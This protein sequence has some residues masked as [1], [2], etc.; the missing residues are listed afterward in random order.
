LPVLDASHFNCSSLAAMGSAAIESAASRGPG[1]REPSAAQNETVIQTCMQCGAIVGIETGAE[2][3]IETGVET[4]VCCVCGARLS[5]KNPEDILVR[6]ST[7]GAD[8][9]AEESPAE[10][11]DNG[12]EA[13]VWRNEVAY[14]VAAY[15][16]RGRR[17]RSRS[18]QPE[19]RFEGSG[20]AGAVARKEAGVRDSSATARATAAP[21]IP[22]GHFNRSPVNRSTVD[23]NTVDSSA[24]SVS[25]S[26]R[27]V[28]RSSHTGNRS[29]H[30][31]RRQRTWEDHLVIDVSQP[32]LN[33]TSVDY[34]PQESAQPLSESDRPCSA[35]AAL[36]E[37][38]R[39]GAIDAGL[40]LFAYGGFLAL[41]WVLGGRFALSALDA[42]ITAA[43]LGLLYAQYCFLFAVF[44]GA[45]PGMMA[46]GLNVVSF[47]GTEPNTR[48]LL[49]RS[50]GYLASAGV[51]FAGFL[52]ALWDRD[53][54]TWHDR[55]SHTYIT[56]R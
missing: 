41:F 51:G 39:A 38:A 13:P 46:R 36:G 21:Q 4:S 31:A 53:H 35:A 6:T 48:Q 34:Y 7:I 29:S 56:F 43:T 42:A 16:A 23:S 12:A 11:Q 2:T 1:L 33:F 15:R 10:A 37:R 44:G 40:L 25:R 30:S 49:W 17:L 50:A 54:L 8:A 19:F 27:T 28:D 18:T 45:T 52:W 5:C 24:R 3:G 32:M 22:A 47:D 26:S 9:S 20:E 14:R 55:I